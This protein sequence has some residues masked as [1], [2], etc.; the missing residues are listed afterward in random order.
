MI[1]KNDIKMMRSILLA[2]VLISLASCGGGGGGGGSSSH[3]PSQNTSTSPSSNYSWHTATQVGSSDANYANLAYSPN[4]SLYV[5]YTNA[6][7]ALEVIIRPSGQS[8][9]GSPVQVS[10]NAGCQTSAFYFQS[11]QDIWL[12]CEGYQDIFIYPSTNGGTSWNAATI[13]SASND[14]L[15]AAYNNLA[16]ASDGST[17]TLYFGY[18]YNTHAIGILNYVYSAT[19]SAGS[20]GGSSTYLSTA[21]GISA[22]IGGAAQNPSGDVVIATGGIFYSTDG[23]NFT[24]E[25]NSGVGNQKISSLSGVGFTQAQDGTLFVSSGYGSNELDL[26]SSSNLGASWTQLTAIT[27]TPDLDQTQIAVSSTTV[28]AVAIVQ[29]SN[30]S[31]QIVATVSYDSGTTWSALT[32][33][34]DVSSSPNTISAMNLQANAGVFSLVYSLEDSGTAEGT[35]LIEFY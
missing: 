22:Q 25:Q 9:F 21:S 28:M 1:F 3:S 2:I 31:V 13:Y 33:I 15:T 18:S 32:T 11:T 29:I 20:W 35:Y 6:S 34:V 7:G 16:F 24:R 12:A 23:I 27:G 10:S 14:G 8:S 5:A 26:W 19:Y 17:V 4:G 30:Q